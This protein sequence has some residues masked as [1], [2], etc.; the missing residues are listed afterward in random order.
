MT[1]EQIGVFVVLLFALVLF[2]TERWRYDI[3]ALLAL[4]AVTLAGIVPADRAFLGFGHAAVITVAAVLVIGRAL[5]NS[6]LVDLLA[7]WV[8]KVGDRV[9]LQVTALTGVVAALS[10]FM[11]NVGALALL[12]PIA[13]RMARKNGHPPSMLLMPLSFGSLLGGMTTLIGTPPNIIIASFRAQ[14][15]FGPFRMFDFTPV[16]ITV[17]LAGILF[18]SLIGWRLIPQ[19]KGQLSPEEL[20]RIEDYVAEVRV[21]EDSKLAGKFVREVEETVE[22]DIT[23]VGLG[24]GER[25]LLAPSS[26]ERLQTGDVLIVEADSEA[27][28]TFLDATKLE[29]IGD[30]KEQGNDKGLGSDEV[31]VIEAIVKPNSPLEGN[32]AWTFNLR[33][34][35]GINLLGVARQGTRLKQ[36]LKSIQFQAGDILLLQGPR[37][38]LQEAL[39]VVGCLPLA[40]RGLHFGPQRLAL[41]L[42]IFT[43]SIA[44]AAGGFLAAP[45]ALAGAAVLMVLFKLISLR[46]AYD[47]IDWPIIVL[48]GA[49]LPLGAAMETTGA[50]DLVANGLLKISGQLPPLATLIIIFL[51]VMFLSDIINNAAAAVLMAP[52]AMSVAQGMG[53]S[54]DPF[55]MAVAVGASSAFLTPIGHQ[56]NTLVMGPGG[57]KFSDYARMGFPLEVIIVLVAVPLILWFWPLGV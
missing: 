14:T 32:T 22:S 57:Y 42:T 26:Y 50:A 10:A 16:G 33:W 55:L 1:T 3:V 6:G 36:R 30:E 29:L 11:N 52:I 51:G 9:T 40:E 2:V 35:Y 37:E 39:S 13:I 45:I 4:L 56:S 20:F 27:L 31:S 21:P 28:K 12:L 49:M 53:A 48:L 7:N 38:R 47:S 54:P 8:L 23:V 5:Q 46:E 24:R 18:M 15:D 19:R 34:R 17:A 44:A 41:S 43:V 25:K